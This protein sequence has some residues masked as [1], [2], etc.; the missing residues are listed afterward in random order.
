MSV[1]LIYTIHGFGFQE[2]LTVK[3]TEEILNDLKNGKKPAPGP[4]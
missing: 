4:R 1:T 3:D 2:D